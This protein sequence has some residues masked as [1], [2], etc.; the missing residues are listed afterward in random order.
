MAQE[1]PNYD[2]IA[3]LVAYVIAQNEAKANIEARRA[4][5]GAAGGGGSFNAEGGAGRGGPGADG[6]DWRSA[7]KG[8]GGGGGSGGGGGGSGGGSGAQTSAQLGAIL[9][10]LPGFGEIDQLMRRLIKHKVAGDNNRAHLFPLHSSMP[11]HQ[12][13]RVFK[14]M[15]PGVTKVS[16]WVLFRPGVLIVRPVQKDG[17]RRD[18]G[19][20]MGR[21][22]EGMGRIGEAMGR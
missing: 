14:R 20:A 15:P 6:G 2:L 7:S 17:P 9:V 8:K 1:S 12:Q 22:R 11:S 19:E 13:R 10:F 18:Q 21:G 5:A 4:G 16:G 3:D